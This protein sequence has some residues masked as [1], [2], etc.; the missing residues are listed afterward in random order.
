MSE[1]PLEKF[2]LSFDLKSVTLRAESPS[3]FLE[4]SGRG[5]RRLSCKNIS[6]GLF[7]AREHTLT[8]RESLLMRNFYTIRPRKFHA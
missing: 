7:S 3:I 2:V 6:A 4:K 1:S 5:R 8:F